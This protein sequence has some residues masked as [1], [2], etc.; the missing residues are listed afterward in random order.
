MMTLAKLNCLQA[1]VLADDG[2]LMIQDRDVGCDA[3][4]LDSGPPEEEEDRP[5]WPC[6]IVPFIRHAA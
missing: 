5:Y 3:E 6:H 2:R 1:L 4:G